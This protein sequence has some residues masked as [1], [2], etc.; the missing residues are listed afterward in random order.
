MVWSNP[1]S[2]EYGLLLPRVQ[3]GELT[4]VIP[5]MT[6]AEAVDAKRSF[7]GR[8]IEARIIKR[9]TSPWEEIH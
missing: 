5:G 4:Q 1:E 3:G 6:H 7:E 8:E 2:I 9:T